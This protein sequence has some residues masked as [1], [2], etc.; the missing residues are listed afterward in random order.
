M[1]TAIPSAGMRATL[2]AHHDWFRYNFD[3][4]RNRRLDFWLFSL[5][6]RGFLGLLCLHLLLCFF[7]V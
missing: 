4:L 2:R 3:N 1:A 6:Y 5:S 7:F